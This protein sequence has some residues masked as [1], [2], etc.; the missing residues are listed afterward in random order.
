MQF[1]S[2]RILKNDKNRR[3]KHRMIFKLH[4]KKSRTDLN[5]L[6]IYVLIT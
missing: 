5:P 2:Y 4:S 1:Y 6:L 3:K